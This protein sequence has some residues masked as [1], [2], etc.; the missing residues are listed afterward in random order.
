M[1]EEATRL[2]RSHAKADTNFTAI[3]AI[4]ATWAKVEPWGYRNVFAGVNTFQAAIVT[5]YKQSYVLFGYNCGEM[6]WSSSATYPT[7]PV[8][9]FNA[10]G[11]IYKNHALSYSK[12]S[13][14]I[15]CSPSREYRLT[16]NIGFNDNS[17][18]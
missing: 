6:S 3:A 11:V 4:V 1:L 8:I 9:G 17:L 12:V 7:S 16:V 10:G 15:A 14:K 5:D 2:S 13:H 18:F